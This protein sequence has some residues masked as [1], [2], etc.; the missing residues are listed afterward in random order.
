MTKTAL[1]CLHNF[2]K[3]VVLLGFG[4]KNGLLLRSLNMISLSLKSLVLAGHL[5]DLTFFKLVFE[6]KKQCEFT[7]SYFLPRY[8]VSFG[9]LILLLELQ[10]HLIHST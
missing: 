3:K 5:L 7:L 1:A 6:L 10:V 8:S 4:Y 9:H 2:G